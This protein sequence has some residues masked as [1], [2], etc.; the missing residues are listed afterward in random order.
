MEP[1]PRSAP[2]S[3]I[4]H[5]ASVSAVAPANAIWPSRCRCSAVLWVA[6][7]LAL[8]GSLLLLAS[9]GQVQAA[10]VTYTS[11]RGVDRYETAVMIS[12]AMF[13]GGLPA[14]SGV[15]LAP[16]A[17]FPEALCGAP[18]ATV[19]G[20]P[21]LLTP[22]EG[23]D[24]RVRGEMLRLAPAEVIC[25]GLSQ[26]VVDQVEGA[27]GTG[28]MVKAING[29]DVYDLS[30]RVAVA[31]GAK[32]GDMSGATA[33]IARGDVF[34]DVIGVSPL[35]CANRWPVLLT[36]GSG[37]ALHASAVKAL[38]ELGISRAIKVGTYAV[39]PGWVTGR[40][41]LSGSNRYVTNANVAEWAKSH[42]GAS[43]A[44]VGL[45]TGEKFPDALAAGPYLAMDGGVLLLSP[46]SGLPAVI[47]AELAANDPAVGHVSLIAMIR[48]VSSQ[49]K[50]LLSDLAFDTSSAMARLYQLSVV[51][52]PRKGG[53]VAELAAAQYG[54]DYL[55]SLGYSPTLMDV[56][57]PNGTTSHNVIA[58]KPGA[59]PLTIVVG[60]HMDSKLPSPG[61]N[62]N[63]SGSATVLELAHALK[64]VTLVPTVIFVLFGQEETVAGSAD[65]HHWGSRRYV[66]SM[67]AEERA[68]L[69]GMISLDMVGNG[70]T[71]YYRTM[72]RGPRA[73]RDLMQSYASAVRANI[74][75]L[76]DSS[77]YGYS[78]HE[79]FELS[80][81]PSVWL[82][83]RDDP[84][85][86][87]SGDTY[88]HCSAACVER[89]GKFALGFL[90]DLDMSDLY[91][92]RA[93]KR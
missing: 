5:R 8:A 52:G 39:L 81:L 26:T 40:A 25:I 50:G 93:A 74:K 58:V 72:E 60:G 51:I 14:G 90:A 36:K 18:L 48:P 75:Y 43:F 76:K 24:Y 27:L 82:E 71:F 70:Q 57:L 28:V 54:V 37:G 84:A 7:A 45:A 47:R 21:V 11:L 91:Y 22:G 32:V 92:L 17:T 68:D 10:G 33:V 89:A 19:Y 56:S 88:A 85:Y 16:G 20:G 15:V 53:T 61:G 86:H 55:T 69:V 79:P 29:T 65:D 34:A 4:S 49:V 83:W 59:S 2:T 62:D 77:T 23:L 12:K 64:D 31:L 80:G 66:A 46:L 78:D 44:H 6:V 42:G 3:E 9:P 1:R 73:M 30:Y 35:A 67:T 13:P 41:N 87:S 38:T 63:G